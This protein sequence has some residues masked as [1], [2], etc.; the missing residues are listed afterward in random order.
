MEVTHPWLACGRRWLAGQPTVAREFARLCYSPS[1]RS[2][3]DHKQC[4]RSPATQRTRSH[5]FRLLVQP[6]QCKG[7]RRASNGHAP[8]TEQ[9]QSARK[10]AQVG[11]RCSA[12]RE[13]CRRRLGVDLA[14]RSVQ[15]R[16]L[17]RSTA[18]VE[19]PTGQETRR[20]CWQVH[21]G[22]GA[23]SLTPSST[24]P[25]RWWHCSRAVEEQPPWNYVSA[26][27]KYSAAKI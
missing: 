2:H 12:D 14:R 13:A 26:N 22:G 27:T 7:R 1:Y 6:I 11:C 9:R 4:R 16:Q 20:R 10:H 19:T 8:G 25:W 18:P 21:E 5:M 15:P 3:D 23:R 24:M 17:R